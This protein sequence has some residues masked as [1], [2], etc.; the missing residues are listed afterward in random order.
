MGRLAVQQESEEGPAAMSSPPDPKRKLAV[1][2]PHGATHFA[3]FR[4]TR[5]NGT[6][7]QEKMIGEADE[8][9]YVPDNW[10]V[11]EFS[12]RNVLSQW[13]EGRYRV[14][15]YSGAEGQRMKGAGASFE[16]A[17]PPRGKKPSRKL[18]AAAAEI[19]EAGEPA[20]RASAQ[21][22]SG[23]PIG[24]LELMALLEART[25]R[26]EAKAAAQAERDRQFW[27]QQAT[28][29]Q[30]MLQTLLTTLRGGGSGA[31]TDLLRREMA[32]DLDRKMFE[33]R[34][35][36]AAAQQ[37][38][39]TDDPDDT[40]DPPKDLE[41]AAE[42]IGMAFLSQLEGA[43]PELVQKMIPR[44]LSM[45]KAQGMQPSPEMQAKIAAAANGAHRG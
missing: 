3:I 12:T 16:V 17:A 39:D 21:I 42:R 22:A 38:D 8:T 4:L 13:G 37:P 2:A 23:Q 27:A 44:F 25:D 19:E 15:W 6:S 32:L 30:N 5:V 9:G 11:A 20:A 14:E 1:E 26:A 36:M 24:V 33:L 43:A 34:Q 29:Q 10:P 45:L 28:A 41:E 35:E 7:K 40:P 18:R 31:E